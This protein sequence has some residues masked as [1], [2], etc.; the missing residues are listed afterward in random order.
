M[1]IGTARAS[2][3]R[4]PRVRTT[5]LAAFAAGA[6]LVLL[7]APAAANGRFPS[8]GQIVFAPNDPDLVILRT[9]FGLLVSR[10]HGVTWRWVCESSMGIVALQEDPSIGV[11]QAGSVVG[12]L[13]E[14]VSVS[15]DTGCNWALA[16]GA[17]TKQRIA[18]LVVRP[19][20]PHAVL[21]ITGTW[22][23][24]AGA[25]DGGTTYYLSQIYRSTDDGADWSALGTPVDPSVVV[26]TMEVAKSDPQRI[27]VSGFRGESPTRSPAFFV[28]ADQGA[29][30][31]ERS[32]S[33]AGAASVYIAAVDPDDA[34]LVYVRSDGP[35]K[36]YVTSNGG[37]SFATPTFDAPDGGT[38][39]SLTGYM[40]G[41]ALSPDGSKIYLGGIQDGLF[42][43]SRGASNF[44]H[45]SSLQVECLAA[46]GPEL[47]ACSAATSDAGPFL[48]GVSADDGVT[49]APKLHLTGVEG[50]L[51]CNADAGVSQCAFQFGALC[52]RL[53]GCVTADADAGSDGGAA[54]AGTIPGPDAGD[55]PP[56]HPDAPGGKS[57]CGCAVPGGGETAGF[58][59]ALA[60]LALA[61][62][63]SRRR[64]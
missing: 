19:D 54:D 43:A 24:D 26:T 4:V 58:A 36:L 28:S 2:V 31:T 41:F 47:W 37:Q 3:P 62:V 30:W 51:A 29:T 1:T 17:L 13:W 60:V 11:T 39:A 35:S 22:L 5:A 56:G 12:G 52:Q 64:R 34:D 40:F 46:H 21:I 20:D 10:D 15:P 25:P 27:Y 16:G 42:M 23:P 45:Q 55:A 49:F 48:A 50:V 33:L 44:V 57:S 7:G 8:A 61:F 38:M 63:R 59:G 6:A 32:A 9:T 14:G 53:G 18:D